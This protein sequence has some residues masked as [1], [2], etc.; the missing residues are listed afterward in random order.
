[1]SAI[2]DI[3]LSPIQEQRQDPP[4]QSIQSADG[5][6]VKTGA[7]I[8]T[9]N[10]TAIPLSI[11]GAASIQLPSSAISTSRCL[12]NSV[13]P[14]EICTLDQHKFIEL[15]GAFKKEHLFPNEPNPIDIGP[16]LANTPPGV[17]VSTGTERS[18]ADLLLSDEERCQGLVILDINPNVKAYIDFVI[19]LCRICNSI[20]EFRLLCQ[21]PENP[22][23][24]A[25]RLSEI[26]AKLDATDMPLQMKRYYIDNLK[27]LAD[28]Y[29]SVER[30]WDSQYMKQYPNFY[31]GVRYHED[32]R[33]FAKLQRY[34]KAGNIIAITGTINALGVLNNLPISVV[35]SSNIWEY[36]L[37]YPTGCGQSRP[38]M[39]FT[40]D[41]MSPDAPVKYRSYIHRSFLTPQEE[42]ELNESQK[43]GQPCALSQR[44]EIIYQ[45]KC[46]PDLLNR[47]FQRF[48]RI[49]KSESV[50]DMFDGIEAIREH[51]SDEALLDQMVED[52]DI[53][54][55]LPQLVLAYGKIPLETYNSFMAVKGWDKEFEKKMTDDPQHFRRL[56]QYLNE[57]PKRYKAFDSSYFWKF[58]STLTIFAKDHNLK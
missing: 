9:L 52:P 49:P 31:A 30:W 28:A 23:Q 41:V 16:L 19:L 40:E 44:I 12:E 24:L 56:L 33:L 42:R 2:T 21:N 3:P 15:R 14:Q 4:K 35:D 1:M 20:R 11:G 50:I 54:R 47:F 58:N 10:E 22:D 55:F 18:L 53:M 7:Q 39:I 36:S 27:V 51:S 46:T 48:Y 37:V 38:K 13:A 8:K 45:E 32:E 29:F 5:A 6:I 57:E 34:A 25:A 17:I 43:H 26:A